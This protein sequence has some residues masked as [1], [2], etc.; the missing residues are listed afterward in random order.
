[1]PLTLAPGSVITAYN[2]DQNTK[3]TAI[4]KIYFVYNALTLTSLLRKIAP[5]I[6]TNIGTANLVTL[7][8]KFAICQL[9]V[10]ISASKNQEPDTCN[11]TTAKVA[12]ILK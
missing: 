2:I 10:I 11:I 1:M 9:S 6:I 3:A 8:N 5:L 12:K 4:L 7:L